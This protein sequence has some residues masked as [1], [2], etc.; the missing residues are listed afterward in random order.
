MT[1]IISEKEL[2]EVV[3]QII[4]PVNIIPVNG[5]PL[6]FDPLLQIVHVN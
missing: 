2:M 5:I 1:T 4:E 3:K 6:V